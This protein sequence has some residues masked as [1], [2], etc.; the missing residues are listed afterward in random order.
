MGPI[1]GRAE[2]TRLADDGAAWKRWGPYLSERAWGTVREDY[3]VNGDAWGHLPHDHARSRT[4]RW[5]EDGLAGWSDDQQR[6]CFSLSF[7]NGAD[8][9]LKERI[10]GLTGNEGNHG[11]DAK[12]LWWYLDSTPTHSW[13]RW[14]YVYPQREF[15][16]ERLVGENRARGRLDP[17]FEL[18]DTGVLDEDR[19]WDVVA[20]YAKATP[21]D[22]CIR[23]RV[24]N[25]G[26]ETATL[27]V[28]PTVWFRNTWSWGLDD[29]KPVIVGKDGTLVADHHSLGRMVLVGDGTPEPLFCDNESNSRRLWGVDGT[30]FP[31]DGIADHVVHGA[32]SVNPDLTGTK[33]ALWYRLTVAPGAT[34]DVRL[35]LSP[36][37]ERGR[38]R[39]GRHDGRART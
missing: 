10:F 16:Y 29:R 11:E 27:H 37:A 7:W 14:A 4:Y 18:L 38:R 30:A 12:E 34:A 13:M 33:A 6:L 36:D 9:I 8:P 17:E 1:S 31:K 5:N 19:Y 2:H 21:D 23:V 24:R 25:A 15:P 39:V 32:A 20:D 35:R 22:V 26:P 3:S 28:L